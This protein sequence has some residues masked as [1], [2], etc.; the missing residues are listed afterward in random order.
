MFEKVK[1]ILIF[2]VIYCINEFVK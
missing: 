1:R 2:W